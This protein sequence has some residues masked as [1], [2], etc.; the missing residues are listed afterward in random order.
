MSGGHGRPLA[1]PHPG[2]AAGRS[3]ESDHVPRPHAGPAPSLAP[4]RPSYGPPLPPLVPLHVL[5]SLLRMPVVELP[6]RGSA[7]LR[8]T[9]RA[10]QLGSSD[11]VEWRLEERPSQPIRPGSA[12]AL[13]DPRGYYRGISRTVGRVIGLD[14]HWVTFLLFPGRS[15]SAT[16]QTFTVPAAYTALPLWLRIVRFLLLLYLPDEHPYEPATLPSLQPLRL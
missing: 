1:S 7:L 4:P 13:F 14:R 5:P 15:A 10:G 3:F 11:K 6:I 16:V 12:V 9:A 8:V 2:T